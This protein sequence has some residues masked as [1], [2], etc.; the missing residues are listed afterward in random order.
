MITTNSL[1]SVLLARSSGIKGIDKEVL[2]NFLKQTNLTLR[3]DHFNFLLS[4]GDSSDI[5]TSMFGW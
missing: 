3:P 2:Q 5:L 4:Y 1:L